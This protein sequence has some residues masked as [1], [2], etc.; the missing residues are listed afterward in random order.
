[1][2]TRMWWMVGMIVAGLVVGLNVRAEDAA[3]KKESRFEK[4]DTDGNGSISK[5]EYKVVH[6]RRLAKM[7][8]K[9]GDKYDPA[10]APE[11]D[12]AFGRLDA[13]KNGE[14]TKEEFATARQKAKDAKDGD[15]DEQD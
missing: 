15:D 10:R 2:G 6:E 8:E 1:M 3:P 14:I 9:M 11:M 13:D 7:K 4:M 12:K 5:E